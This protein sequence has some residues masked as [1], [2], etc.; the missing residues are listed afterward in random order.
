MTML[1]ERL[2]AAVADLR[3]ELV[4]HAPPPFSP[5][6]PAGPI[7]AMLV[8]LLLGFG[9]VG[10]VAQSGGD[11]GGEIIT[12]R[13]DV[14][15]VP[16][17]NQAVPPPESTDAPPEDAP[18][19]EQGLA[20]AS[21]ET[22]AASAWTELTSPAPGEFVM[23]IPL[24]IAWSPDE[25]W[26]LTYR[27]GSGEVGHQVWDTTNLA[28]GPIPLPFQPPDIEQVYW[29]P[30]E[31]DTLLY[32][33]GDDAELWKF[34]L[35]SE[36]SSVV[37]FF[38]GC[39][40]LSSGVSPVPPATDGTVSLLCEGA[41]GLQQISYN[42]ATGVEVRVPTMS[43]TAAAPSPSGEVLVRWNVDG[44]AS[45][46]NRDLT[47]TGVTLDL[48]D[49]SFD[50][51]VDDAGREWAVAPLFDGAAIGSAVLLPL[52]GGDAPIVLIGPDAG[53][54]YPPSGTSISTAGDKIAVSIRGEDDGLAG[55]IT[56]LDL[57][58]SWTD[59]PRRSIPHDSEGLHDYWSTPFASINASG[60]VIYSTDRG[61]DSVTSIVG[62]FIAEVEPN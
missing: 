47:E 40:E 25:R 62:D 41:A 52:D 48:R 5:N 28:A 17:D 26:V 3:H 16:A 13:P 18:V 19:D 31:S 21:P 57:G 39:T 60:H 8:V 50:F 55:R 43:D 22:P 37:H 4:D 14:P 59:P 54:Q 1:D 24:G 35:G 23:P 34:E 36:M 51:V 61:G 9:A 11:V 58:V 44:S 27:T 6:R 32:A 46:L 7:A 30:L 49:N 33:E 45:V 38:D 42:L 56:V 2:D 15:E 12:T 20:P 29:H 10:Y 53:D